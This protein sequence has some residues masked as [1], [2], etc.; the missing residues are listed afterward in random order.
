M[1]GNAVKQAPIA[2]SVVVVL[3]VASHVQA[4]SAEGYALGAA[5]G[6][7]SDFGSAGQ[8]FGGGV[9]AE[10]Y[11]TPRFGVGGDVGGFT[12]ENGGGL[13]SLSIDARGH[14]TSGRASQRAVPFVGGG[15]SRLLFF[16]GADD[17][18]NL[19]GGV[20]YRFSDSRGL[21]FEIRDMIRQE[22]SFT[23]HFWAVRVGV[24]FR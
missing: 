1:G 6:W 2:F 16:E 17:A 11:M 10:F 23:T 12:T 24:I 9:G 4:Q 3:A 15:Y 7:N 13:L 14:L 5:G 20:D 18:F 19:S 8:L 21:R 22:R